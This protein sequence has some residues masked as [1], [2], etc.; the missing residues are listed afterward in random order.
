[1]DP[2]ILLDV[3]ADLNLPSNSV[4]GLPDGM[5]G[6]PSGGQGRRG[7][8]GSGDQGGIGDASGPGIQGIAV[9]RLRAGTKPPVVLV[10]TE[11]EYSEQAR[12]ARVQ[13]TIVVEGVIDERGL[14]STLQVRDG[15]GFGLDEQAM[16]AVRQW[17]FRP[18][19]RDGK[20]VPTVGIFYL[21]F[22]LL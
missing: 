13:G 7:G 20:P 15:L 1:M 22:R 9:E 16:E 17:R 5:T 18:A 10:K 8:I 12:K 14:T 6:L 3:Q 4:L 2:V 11:P 21:T 19:T